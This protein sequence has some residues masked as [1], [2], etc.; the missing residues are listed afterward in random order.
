MGGVGRHF[1][2]ARRI[3]V[4]YPGRSKRIELY[5]IDRPLRVFRSINR[6]LDGIPELPDIARPGIFLELSYRAV[7]K[8]RPVGPV[9]FYGH[10]PAEMFGQQRDIVDP[11]AQAGH[12]E[13]DAAEPVEQVLPELAGVHP[14]REIGLAGRHHP[15]RVVGEAVEHPDDPGLLIWHGIIV[16]SYAGEK[17]G[18]GA[19]GLVKE[20]RG[21]LQHALEIDPTALQGSAHTS[22][23]SLYYKVPGWPIGFGSDKEA[24]RHLEAALAINPG[25]IDPNYFMGEF[26]F[27]EGDF[28]QARHYLET[29]LAAPPRPQRKLADSGRRG[30]IRTLLAR[31]EQR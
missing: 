19:L 12:G 28:E 6:P 30:E 29:A 25:G 5:L 4:Q 13:R 23:G 15:R 3:G 14:A 1:N 7:R 21:S 17:G 26:L 8:A 16:S 11:L 27:E 18:L 10:P 22:L 24:R 9:E 31:L 20:A 2:G